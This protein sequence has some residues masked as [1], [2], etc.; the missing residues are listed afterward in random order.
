MNGEA[1]PRAVIVDGVRWVPYNIAFK[2]DEG[3]FSFELF[4]VNI[5]HAA[6]RLE[7]LKATAEIK[8]ELFGS[9]TT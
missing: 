2:T 4:A 1:N 5:L 6:A 8:G 9:V 7:D 3:E